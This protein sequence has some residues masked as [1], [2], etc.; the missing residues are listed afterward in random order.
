M[1]SVVIPVRNGERFLPQTLRSVLGQTFRELDVVVVDDGSTDTTAEIVTSM[2]RGD[3]R[4]RYVEAIGAGVAAAR[5]QGIEAA[6]SDLIAPVDADDLWLPDKIEL[7]V[8]RLS[9]AGNDAALVYSWVYLIDVEDRVAAIL[10]PFDEL[11]MRSMEGDVFLPLLY[12]SFFANGSAPL[13]R[14]RCI[15]E[16]GGYDTGLSRREDWDLS[17]RLAARWPFALVP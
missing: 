7:Q 17:L 6:R 5:N 15:E 1:V 16:V 12:K 10:R 13:I 3:A 11:T 8:Q 2:A 4:V 9:E 14:R